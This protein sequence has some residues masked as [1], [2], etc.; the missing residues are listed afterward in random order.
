MSH[1]LHATDLLDLRLGL[2]PVVEPIDGSRFLVALVA[3]D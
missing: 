2:V 1:E 3:P